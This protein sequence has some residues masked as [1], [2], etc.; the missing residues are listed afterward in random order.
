[1]CV[2]EWRGCITCA[3]A[4]RVTRGGGHLQIQCLVGDAAV[5]AR[6]AVRFPLNLAANVLKVVEF[7]SPFLKEGGMMGR[8]DV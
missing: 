5:L 6:Y 7:L 4:E 8:R 1:V 2:S 3:V